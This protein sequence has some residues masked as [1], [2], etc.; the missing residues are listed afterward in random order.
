M[1]NQETFKMTYSAQQQEE[2]QSIREKYLPKVENKMEQLRA[3]DAAVEKKAAKASVLIGT[4][5][6]LVMGIGMS[7]CMSDFG[8]LLG[9]VA[10]PAGI[11]IGVAGIVAV[12][13]AYPIY[14]RTLKKER[15]KAAPEIMR[16]S[17]ELLG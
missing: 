9:D 2:V 15:E 17:D 12:A 3:L 5:G 16:L 4:F 10:F 11:A 7:L 13:L 14:V 6:V 8:K 1:E